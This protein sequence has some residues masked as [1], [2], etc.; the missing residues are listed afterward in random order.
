MDDSS[1]KKKQVP[2]QPVAQPAPASAPDV[3][4]TPTSTQSGTPTSYTTPP[5][6]G[7]SKG[8]LW[9]IIGGSIAAVLVVVGIVLAVI[10]LGGPSQQ[11]YQDLA[12]IIRDENLEKLS[13]SFSKGA[14][15]DNYDQKMQEM[16]D[17]V[18][19]LYKKIENSKALRDKELKE[20]FDVY[21]SE[22]N[23]AKPELEE[24]GPLLKTYAQA[25]TKCAS[26][27][28]YTLGSNITKMSPDEIGKEFDNKMNDCVSALD[29]LSR[30]RNGSVAEFGKNMRD[31]YKQLKEYYV[32]VAKR[33]QSRDFSSKA[34]T[35]PKYPTAKSPFSSSKLSD[36]LK[37]LTEAEKDFMN[38]LNSKASKG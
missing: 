2:K 21:Y 1:S 6:K 3:S 15:V 14:T 8:A 11:D 32:G 38:M 23:K 18:D 26:S 34:P 13:S 30:S 29:E 10:L 25:R 28:L 12:N 33:Y 37:K 17:R 4:P 5:K 35:Y 27:K 22:W 9:G 31:Y 19:G 7:L 36:T 24:L 20:K 16:I